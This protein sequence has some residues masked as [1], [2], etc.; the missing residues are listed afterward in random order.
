MFTAFGNIVQKKSLVLAFDWLC[1]VQSS[2]LVVQSIH[3]CIKYTHWV[4]SKRH[5]LWFSTKTCS[6]YSTKTYVNS[7]ILILRLNLTSL[8]NKIA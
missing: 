6:S 2:G 1:R 5:R 3:M 4:Q 7:V 8:R